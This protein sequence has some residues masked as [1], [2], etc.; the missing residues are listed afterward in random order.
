MNKTLYSLKGGLLLLVL[1]LLPSVAVHA[2]QE[3]LAHFTGTWATAPQTPV[4]SFM[5]YNNDMSNRSVR[6]IVKVSAGGDIVKLKLTNIFSTEPVVIQS[7]YLAEATDSFSVLT[8]GAHYFRFDGKRHVTIAAGGT[9]TSDAMKFDLRPL[10]KVAITINYTKAPK[11]PTVHMGSRTTSY[12]MK[13]A[14][15]PR[16]RFDGCFPYEKWFNLAALDVYTSNVR[17]VAILGNSITDGKGSTTNQQNRWPDEMSEELNRAYA[18]A[19]SLATTRK[20]PAAT[21]TKNEQQWAVLNL[22]IG[23]NRVLTTGFGQPAKDRF[24]RDIL[25]QTGLTD[26]IIFEGINDLGT[27]RDGRTTARL[28]I[29]QY[30]LMIRKAKARRLRV[31]LATIT[32]MKGAGY[33]SADHEAGRETVNRWIREQHEADGV[34]D[35]DELMR[36]PKDPQALRAAWR[37]KDCLHPNAEGYRQMGRFAAEKLRGPQITTKTAKVAQR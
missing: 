14:T 28:L 20:E 13:G 25:G 17:T 15:T 4:K 29:E 30:Q 21:T 31:W 12:I 16:T 10:E 7:V 22:G 34:I 8:H 37:L 23:N 3:L 18:K 6:Q 1:M 11:V 26:V 32:P 35:F 33:F 36:D 24:N 19:F 9:A 5:P 2:Q 27:S